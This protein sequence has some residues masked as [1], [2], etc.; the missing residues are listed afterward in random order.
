MIEKM[1][2]DML[3]G[4]SL[5]EALVHPDDLSDVVALMVQTKIDPAKSSGNLWALLTEGGMRVTAHDLFFGRGE[6]SHFP[7]TP[8]ISKFTLALHRPVS[9]P[10][11]FLAGF[12]DVLE[13]FNETL[14]EWHGRSVEED[15]QDMMTAELWGVELSSMQDGKMGQFQ[16]S[17]GTVRARYYRNLVLNYVRKTGKTLE[18][19]VEE[20]STN[21]VYLGARLFEMVGEGSNF[22]LIASMT[23]K[24][25]LELKKAYASRFPDETSL[26]AMAGILDANHYIFVTQRVTPRQIIDLARQTEGE[27]D[28]LLEFIVGLETL[29]LS[30]DAPELSGDVVKATCQDQTPAIRK[31]IDE[32][33]RSYSSSSHITSNTTAIMLSPQFAQVRSAAGV[34]DVSFL[35]NLRRMLF[36]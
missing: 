25:Y 6:E 3:A 10:L 16:N 13:W 15:K 27:Q 20:G 5:E 4:E 14:V 9:A 21:D 36:G 7:S 22:T 32:T 30:I 2:R 31:S 26:L 18:V 23:T 12:P 35:A 11:W 33:I 1:W 29:L 17:D 8:S 34:R 19:A 28:R 24:Y